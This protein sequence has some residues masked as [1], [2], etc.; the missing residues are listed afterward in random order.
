[1][2]HIHLEWGSQKR[3][4][5]GQVSLYQWHGSHPCQSGSA[6]D[7]PYRWIQA[8]WPRV[9]HWTLPG[10]TIQTADLWIEGSFS[11][12]TMLHN[13]WVGM[14]AV[15]FAV[16]KCSFYLYGLPHFRVTTDHKPLEGFFKKELFEVQNPWLQCIHEKLLPYTFTLRWL[17]VRAS[18][19]QCIIQSTIIFA[20]RHWWHAH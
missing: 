10:W 9:C 17:R 18:Y 3:I 15:H 4:W 16:T 11:D 1:M 14:L 5:A 7:G 12:P 19:C 6:G 2:E 8:S 13:N 20:S